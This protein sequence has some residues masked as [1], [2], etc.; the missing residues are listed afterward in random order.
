M[1]KDA[2]GRPGKLLHMHLRTICCLYKVLTLLQYNGE[3]VA[4]QSPYLI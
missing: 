4:A 2:K 1:N 3:K